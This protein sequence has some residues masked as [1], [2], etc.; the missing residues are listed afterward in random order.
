MTTASLQHIGVGIDT[1]RYGHRVAFLREDRQPAAPAI[2]VTE[3]RAG[4]DRLH[5][6]LEQLHARHPEACIHVHLDAAGQYAANLEN[7]LRGLSLPLVVSIGEPKRNKDYHKAFSPKRS[8][9]DTES[10]MMSRFAVV[11]R[12]RPTP[13]TPDEFAL[14]REIAGR[15]QAQI[16][17]TRR[18]VNRLHNLL[19]R[20]FPELATL[21]TDLSAEW[22]LTLLSRYP[23]AERVAAARLDSLK[24]IPFLKA[25]KAE[26]IHQ[27]A[28][29]SIASLRGALA[30][31]L[32]RQ[33]VGH[34]RQGRQ[35]EKELE[36]LLAA[37]YAELP[38]SG[39][40]QLTTIPGIGVATAAVLVAKIISIDRFPTAE[41][42][43]GYFGVFPEENS[44]GVD[45]DGRPLPTGSR[46]MSPRGCDLA[47]RYL[48]SAARSAVLH[49]AP[50]RE[51]YARLRAR[52]TRGDVALG[53]CM[54]KLLHQVYGVWTSD[55]PFDPEHEARRRQ[56]A[57]PTASPEPPAPVPVRSPNENG[58]GPQA[59]ACPAT[60]SGHRSRFPLGT[61]T[62]THAHTPSPH[63]ATT[64]TQSDSVITLDAS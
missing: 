4:Y 36:A 49:N 17:D 13:C 52:G 12:P 45:R 44:S 26:A 40:A 3:N 35:N 7:F 20:A 53:H 28:R 50:I 54:R 1:A 21:T 38:R 18:A 56:A 62:L 42:L 48:W 22:V 41:K 33:L 15:L 43:V 34:V 58:C 14:L 5:L 10:L 59:G 6:Q 63:P 47:R 30:E 55:S 37:A 23:T 8:D 61:P 57:V 39:H 24:K 32:V 16:K 25:E 46:R 9:D 2:T 27:A 11:E 64:P 29:Q 60:E 31:Q 51:L 19:A